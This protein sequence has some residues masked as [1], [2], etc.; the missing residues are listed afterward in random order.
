MLPRGIKTH[1]LPLCFG[2]DRVVVVLAGA[3][4]LILLGVILMVLKFGNDA[5]VVGLVVV[6][7]VVI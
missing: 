4:T 7:G 3:V 5:V 1:K 6:V 2:N